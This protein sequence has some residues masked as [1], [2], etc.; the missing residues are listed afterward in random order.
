M[1]DDRHPEGS[2]SFPELMELPVG[3]IRVACAWPRVRHRQDSIQRPLEAARAPLQI[4]NG[5]HLRRSLAVY[6]PSE[7][8]AMKNPA[9]W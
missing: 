7:E 2:P 8:A 1:A 9:R 6:T 4:A 3:I 5:L